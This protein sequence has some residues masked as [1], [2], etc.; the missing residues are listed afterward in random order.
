MLNGYREKKN[1][2][3]KKRVY[4]PSIVV[5]N[6]VV[7]LH[8]DAVYK[9]KICEMVE[10]VLF[11]YFVPCEVRFPSCMAF[12]ILFLKSFASLVCRVVFFLFLNRK[13]TRLTSDTNDFVNAK[14]HT[15]EK[16]LNEHFKLFVV[17][18]NNFE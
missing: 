8:I 4:Y 10:S 18:R 5:G 14:R 9:D 17:G 13:A 6:T 1:S 11:R 3:N 12:S 7:R 2:N 15:R 16:P